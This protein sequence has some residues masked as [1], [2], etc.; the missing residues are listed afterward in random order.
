MERADWARLA[1][2]QANASV[3]RAG[4]RCD[5][6][7]RVPGRDVLWLCALVRNLHDEL[8]ES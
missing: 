7:T 8:E 4:C 5:E 6:C 1:E 3:S 2:I